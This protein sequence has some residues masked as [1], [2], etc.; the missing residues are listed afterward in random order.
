MKKKKKKVEL[1]FSK[2]KFHAL[3]K[4]NQTELEGS[5]HKFHFFFKNGT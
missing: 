1:E 4:K 5:K 2:L 3:K